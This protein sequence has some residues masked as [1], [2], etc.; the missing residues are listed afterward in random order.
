MT[1]SDYF[2]YPTRGISTDFYFT[3]TFF[4]VPSFMMLMFREIY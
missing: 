2:K 4:V 3:T 1:I